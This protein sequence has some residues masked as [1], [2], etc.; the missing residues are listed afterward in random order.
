LLKFL[1]LLIVPSIVL[2]SSQEK[3][4]DKANA[5]KLYEK[6]EWKALLHYK[7]TLNIKDKAFILSENFSLNNELNATIKSFY[8]PKQNYK[9]INNHPQC[10]FP[11]R[12]LFISH[13]LALDTNEFP[14]I[15]CLALATYR[16]KAPADKIYVTY[17]SEN[18]RNPSSMMGHTFLKF[19]GKNYQGREVEHAITFYTVLGSIN[20]FKLAYQNI[21]S[22]MDGLFALQPYEKIIRQYTDKE[23][24]NVWEYQLS[25]SEYR[26]KLIY[27]HVWELKGIDMKYFFSSYNCSTVIYY[28]LSLVNPK[29]Y[30]EFKLWVTPLDTVKMLYKYNLIQKSEL[31]PSHTWLVKMMAQSLNEHEIK[32][33]Q[34]KEVVLDISQYKSP[35]NIPNERQ[36]GISYSYV[37]KE[38]FLKLSFLPASHFLN[39]DNREYFGESE[40]KIAYLSVLLNEE[41]LEL[42]EFTLYGM[43]SY[44]PFDTQTYDLSYQFEL[45]VMKEYSRNLNYEN[46]LKLD[47]GMGVDFLLWDD[48][49]IFAMFNVGIGYN[50]SDNTHLF[51]N[52]QIGGT[53]YEVF[54]MKSLLYYQPLFIYENKVYDKY[55][56]NHNIFF[57]KDYK[58]YF[59]FEQI[60]ADT[61]YTN[62]EF[63]FS[64]LF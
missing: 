45:G 52:P 18:V 17:A 12:L 7:K 1:F 10:R 33:I 46:T 4:L 2:Y 48:I 3:V 55:I 60:N 41:S 37:N 50:N 63:G 40:L 57:S 59:N 19:S 26:R 15:D 27:Y 49:N 8:T 30:D 14:Y 51:F 39:D 35:N 32:A 53:I 6:N 9:N 28:S 20:I 54:N 38:N 44:I 13:E 56:L 11:A 23:N 25:L 42:D 61:R 43:K 5:L 58:F 31:F 24:R 64:K 29:L 22:G 34:N 62:Y 16:K 47:G 36:L 21:F